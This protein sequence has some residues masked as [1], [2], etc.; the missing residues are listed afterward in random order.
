ML[1]CRRAWYMKSRTWRHR[2]VIH[3]D[4]GSFCEAARFEL[5]IFQRKVCLYVNNHIIIGSTFKSLTFD[6]L[7]TGALTKLLTFGP[8]T[9]NTLLSIPCKLPT[10]CLPVTSFTWFHVPGPPAFQCAYTHHWKA[11]S[12]LGT[13]LAILWYR[14][15]NL[16]ILAWVRGY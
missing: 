12:G 6:P 16:S 13:R 8:P 7:R 11:G 2:H 5:H 4:K 1:K 10:F 14:A 9:H 3:K 15:L